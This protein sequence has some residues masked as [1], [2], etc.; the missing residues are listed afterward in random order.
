MAK[1]NLPKSNSEEIA[2]DCNIK[3][4]TYESEKRQ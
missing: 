2:Q 4:A 1:R 3:T